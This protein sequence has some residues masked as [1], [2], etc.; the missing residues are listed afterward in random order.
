MKEDAGEV[1]AE[2]AHAPEETV[3]SETQPGQRDVVPQVRVGEHPQ[4]T[5]GVEGA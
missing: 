2:G 3:E 1:V 4:E 5:S